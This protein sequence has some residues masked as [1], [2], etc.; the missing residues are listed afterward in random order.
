M[1]LVSYGIAFLI[2][3]SVPLVAVAGTNLPV[4]EPTVLSD[5]QMDSIYGGGDCY[6]GVVA[7][8]GC[9]V[10]WATHCAVTDDPTPVCLNDGALCMK[11]TCR[12]TQHD[13]RWHISGLGCQ[14]LLVPC[15]GVYKEWGCVT[16]PPPEHCECTAPPSSI[17]CP[18]NKLG[19]S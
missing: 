13:C 15:S 16:V 9:H 2:A 17:D 10:S 19:C 8:H 11:T 12:Q 18:G 7:H 1:R 5:A 14:G 6:C 3:I 4:A